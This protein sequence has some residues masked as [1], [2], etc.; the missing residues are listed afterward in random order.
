MNQGP[1]FNTMQLPP[2]GRLLA[3]ERLPGCFQLGCR[4]FARCCC[5]PAVLSPARAHAAP[6][7][8]VLQQCLSS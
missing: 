2:L 1:M 3:T 5:L 4:L 7:H 6:L 8:A